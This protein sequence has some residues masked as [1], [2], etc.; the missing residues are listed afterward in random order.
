[1]KR[2]KVLIPFTCK[3]SGNAYVAGDEI[4]VSDE[5]L[6]AIKSVNVNMVE[7]L[8]EAEE[9][10]VASKQPKKAKKSQKNNE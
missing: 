5:R 3:E 1:M 2:V 4:N 10:T 9:K 8:G 7:I 6:T